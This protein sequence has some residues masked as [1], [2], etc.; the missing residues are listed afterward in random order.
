[1]RCW[2][3]GFTLE[4]NGY[5]SIPFIYIHWILFE[6]IIHSQLWNCEI[7]GS[8]GFGFWFVFGRF[9]LWHS[10]FNLCS[11]QDCGFDGTFLCVDLFFCKMVQKCLNQ[12]LLNSFNISNGSHSKHDINKIMNEEEEEPEEHHKRLISYRHRLRIF[13][14]CISRCDGTWFIIRNHRNHLLEPLH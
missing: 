6:S 14:L 5:L 1:M 8:L 2:F 11:L 3:R 13:G 7:V 12:W 10:H 9:A 4:M